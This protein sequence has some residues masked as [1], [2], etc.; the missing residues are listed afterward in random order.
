MEIMKLPFLVQHYFEHETEEHP[1]LGFGTYLWEHYVEDDHADE[2]KGHC[3]EKLP[4]KHCHDCCA[5]QPVLTV[6][7]VPD[8]FT[9]LQ[10]FQI[11]KA[12]MI[13]F[14]QHVTSS[15]HCC[16]WQPPKIG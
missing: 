11:E 16:I 10:S 3:D 9:A 2:G 5:H 6:C 4:F 12:G 7:T 8:N 1:D 13:L 15:Y 14:D